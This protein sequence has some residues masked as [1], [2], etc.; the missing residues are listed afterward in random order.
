MKRLLNDNERE[1]LSNRNSKDRR[2]WRGWTKSVWKRLSSSSSGRW[3]RLPARLFSSRPGHVS[4]VRISESFQQDLHPGAHTAVLF[5]KQRLIYVYTSAPLTESRRPR[6]GAGPWGWARLLA[7]M[8]RAPGS[9]TA[10]P[11]QQGSGNRKGLNTGRLA[12]LLSQILNQRLSI[13]ISLFLRQENGSDIQYRNHLE[14]G[15]SEKLSSYLEE[16]PF[17]DKDHKIKMTPPPMAV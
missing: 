7:S 3:R 12:Q 5:R 15:S 9:A 8:L 17:S 14:I 4:H 13:W 2:A 16:S 10:T 1:A 11:G 6:H